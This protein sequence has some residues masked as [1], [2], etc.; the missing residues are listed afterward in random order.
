MDDDDYYSPINTA[1]RMGND[2]TDKAPTEE[3][4]K[5]NPKPQ[6][7]HGRRKPLDR[8]PPKQEVSK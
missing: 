7:R 4:P 1:R 8:V 3:R 6:K 5:G 2:I